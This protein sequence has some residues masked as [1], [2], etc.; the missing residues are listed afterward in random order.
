MAKDAEV[1]EDKRADGIDSGGTE[2]REAKGLG[3]EEMGQE[4]EE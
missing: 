3:E 2:R 1:K 4:E